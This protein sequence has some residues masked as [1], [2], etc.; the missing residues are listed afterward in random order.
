MKQR[1]KRTKIIIFTLICVFVLQTAV[2]AYDKVIQQPNEERKLQ[3]QADTVNPQQLSKSVSVAATAV[4]QE[5]EDKGASETAAPDTGNQNYNQF[6]AGLRVQKVYKEELDRLI[7][8]GYSLQNVEITYDYLYQNYGLKSDLENL[9]KQ[10]KSG[11]GWEEIFKDYQKKH[12]PFQPR[13]FDMKDLD[14]LMSSSELQSDDIMI[15][16]RIS[17]VSGKS[18]DEIVSKRLAA[19]SWS[20]VCVE[21]NILQN[22]EQLPRIQVTAEQLE[23][24]VQPGKFDEAEVTRAF[25]MAQKVNQSPET[26]IERM[27]AGLSDEAILAEFYVLKYKQ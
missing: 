7:S 26:V 20:N 11:A 23:K 13:S 17:F 1:S 19:A 8:L 14:A 27:K 9:L 18:V 4:N 5:S 16:D 2:F 15:A 25:V 12:E 21:L 24:Y 3:S 22:P 10:K 6:I